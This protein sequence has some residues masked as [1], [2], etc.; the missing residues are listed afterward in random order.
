M[1]SRSMKSK[2]KGS[3]KVRGEADETQ[4]GKGPLVVET[5]SMLPT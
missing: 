4:G 1:F 3:A 5:M 2:G